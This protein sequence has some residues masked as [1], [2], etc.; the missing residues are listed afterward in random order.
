MGKATRTLLIFDTSNASMVETQNFPLGCVESQLGWWRRVMSWKLPRAGVGGSPWIPARAGMSPALPPA[1][2]GALS[3]QTC[4][5]ISKA[6]P[7]E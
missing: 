4:A 1:S 7:F 3:L 5:L 6:G 2:Q